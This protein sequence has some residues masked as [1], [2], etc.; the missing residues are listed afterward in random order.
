MCIR[1]DG[2]CK[3][4]VPVNARGPRRMAARIL[5]V[6]VIV[7]MGS[8]TTRASGDSICAVGVPR[9]SLNG[10]MPSFC[11]P[12]P[13]LSRCTALCSNRTRPVVDLPLR[14][15][16]ALPPD[17]F[18]GCY[19]LHPSAFRRSL[20]ESGA[21]RLRRFIEKLEAGGD[22]TVVVVGGSVATGFASG[23]ASSSY[24]F[25]EWLQ[26][27]YPSARVARVVL[28]QAGTD[29]FYFAAHLERLPRN[30]DLVIVDYLTN[31]LG[32]LDGDTTPH[33]MR[34]VAEKIVRA[35]LALPLRPAVV[36]VALFR[37]IALTTRQHFA[38]QDI[39]RPT[40]RTRAHRIV[41]I[42]NARRSTRHSPRPTM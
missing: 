10:K 31:D 9:V 22:A 5:R 12:R 26:W 33:T 40:A 2:V 28:A 27:R 35:A 36:L 30:A 41:K 42:Q 23:G 38:F 3:L 39:A 18:N 21:A 17:K 8:G 13:C 32:I 24:Y 16:R 25:L 19:P 20:A 6:L 29:S 14:H 7:L 4:V 11:Q 37:T 15:R 1:M 34:A